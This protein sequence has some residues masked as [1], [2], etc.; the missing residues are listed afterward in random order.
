M[1]Q[2][3]FFICLAFSWSKVMLQGS[4]LLT[5][6]KKVNFE[7]FRSILIHFVWEKANFLLLEFFKRKIQQFLSF[8]SFIETNVW[9]LTKICP[10]TK[11]LCPTTKKLCPTTKILCQTMKNL[12]P[13]TKNLCPTTKNLFSLFQVF[14]TVLN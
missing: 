6:H 11:N 7:E 12:C 4:Q 13:T 2:N 3:V 8:V 9:R 1:K 5:L 14:S 10:T